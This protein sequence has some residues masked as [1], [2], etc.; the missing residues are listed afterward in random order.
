MRGPDQALKQWN[1]ANENILYGA[2]GHIFYPNRCLLGDL[3]TALRSVF[4]RDSVALS[5]EQ[6]SILQKEVE[7]I[8][9]DAIP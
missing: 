4:G 9:S 3:C 6:K 5:D 2:F 8:P 1:M 7:S